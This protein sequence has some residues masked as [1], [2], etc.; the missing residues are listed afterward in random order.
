MSSKTTHYG[1]VVGVD[2]SAASDAAVSWAAH[3]AE[4]RR[5]PLTL[6][7]V[8]D[9]KAPTWSQIMILEQVRGWQEAEG[10]NVLASA[11]K[12]AYDAIGENSAVQIDGELLFAATVPKLIELSRRAELIAVGTD[13]RGALTRGLLGS[14]SSGLVRHAHCPVAVIRD[15]GAP[16]GQPDQRPVLVGIDGSSSSELA[17]KLAFDEASR[18]HVELVAVHAWSDREL[19]ELPGIDWSEVKAEEQRLLSEALAGWRE[20]YP[21]VKVTTSLVCDAPS[22]ALVDA[23]RSAQLVVVGS[24]GRTFAGRLVLGSVSNALVQSARTPVIVARK[25]VR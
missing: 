19:V 7:H 3:D 11:F 18:R 2:G 21:D 16:A 6:V 13:G 5:V 15:E 24:H 25:S 10:R 23:A 14:V 4:M 12:I 22:R 8:E 20:R 17:T 1:I 9:P